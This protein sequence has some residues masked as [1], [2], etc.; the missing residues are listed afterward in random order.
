MYG[1]IE[2]AVKIFAP[3]SKRKNNPWNVHSGNRH[4]YADPVRVVQVL[5][6]LLSNAWKYTPIGGRSLC[7][8]PHTQAVKIEIRITG[9]GLPGRS[10]NAIHPIFRSE[11]P[12]VRDQ[13]GWGLGLNITGDWWR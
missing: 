1:Y 6:N 4:V 11:D 5:T 12:A 9:L 7:S 10:G 2:E 13:Q 3:G 8:S